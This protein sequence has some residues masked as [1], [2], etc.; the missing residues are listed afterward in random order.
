[1]SHIEHISMDQP[2]NT[3]LQ[4]GHL[5]DEKGKEIAKSTQ[6]KKDQ[7]IRHDKGIAEQMAIKH[8]R[9]SHP[10]MGGLGMSLE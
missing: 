10:H 6:K 7:E 9:E 5:P 2:G 8:M 4:E 1:M 3:Q